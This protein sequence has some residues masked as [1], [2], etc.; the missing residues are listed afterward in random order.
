MILGVNVY[1]KAVIVM[2]INLYKEFHGNIN[3]SD[4]GKRLREIIKR[5]KTVFK[6]LTGYGSESGKCQSKGAAIKSLTKM[7]KQGLIKGFLPGE[8]KYELLDNKS[9][10]Y[11]D[12]LLLS[13]IIKDDSDYGND[14][15]IFIFV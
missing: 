9:F 10:Y 14:G 7:K 3:I 12:K 6:I 1:Y 5:E 13:T 11:Q 15:I 2:K 4:I 8:V